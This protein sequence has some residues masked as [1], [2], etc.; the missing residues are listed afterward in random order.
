MAK[1]KTAK[2]KARKKVSVKKKTPRKKKVTVAESVSAL[3]K[4]P[5]CQDGINISRDKWVVCAACLARHH[6]EC[7]DEYGAC[8]TCKHQQML[9]P[10]RATQSTATPS[11][12]KRARAIFR[13]RGRESPGLSYR[14]I[15]RPENVKV[16]R[17]IPYCPVCDSVCERRRGHWGS[18]WGCTRYPFCQGK[19]PQE[20]RGG[21][22]TFPKARPG[23]G[24]GR[25]RRRNPLRYFNPRKWKIKARPRKTTA[26]VRRFTEPRPRI[27]CL[28]KGCDEP[29]YGRLLCSGCYFKITGRGP[30]RS[31]YNQ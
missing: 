26:L 1:K 16:V 9:D 17:G 24:Y 29:S 20:R 14:E 2:K 31:M 3:N 6:R 30:T 21:T 7:W 13:S 28:I 19:C 27:I 10:T 15:Y 11:S 22:W 25:Y 18:F 23:R 8:S 4:C 5:F 12:P